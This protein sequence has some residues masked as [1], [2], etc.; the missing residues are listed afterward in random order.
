MGATMAALRTHVLSVRDRLLSTGDQPSNQ[1]FPI[2]LRLSA[3]AA[4]QLL[5]GDQLPR[6]KD[7]L[8]ANN[9]FVFTIN[10]FPYGSFHGTRVKEKV[11]HPDWTD[12]PGSLTR[13]NCLKS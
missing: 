9:S 10:G 5:E 13:N 11:F 12:P 1:P 7:W 6:F 8:A 4:R 2:G 3:L